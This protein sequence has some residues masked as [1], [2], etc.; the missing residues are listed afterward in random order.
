MIGI[1]LSTLIGRN[2][3]AVELENKVTNSASEQRIEQKPTQTKKNETMYVQERCNIRSSYSADSERVG[4]LDIGTEVTVVAEYS[5]GWYKIRYDGGEA[6]IKA[7][8]L[9]STKPE[10]PEGTEENTQDSEIEPEQIQEEQSQV[11]ETIIE[12]PNNGSTDEVPIEDAELINEIGV[13]PEVGRNIADDLFV[14]MII[15]AMV[16]VIYMKYKFK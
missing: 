7:G 16:L 15:L 4:G 3:Y 13:L 1:F 8:I 12:E 10:V 5:N 9:R 6:Y 11:N 14:G 2:V